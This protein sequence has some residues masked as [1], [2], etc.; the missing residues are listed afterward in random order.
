MTCIC[1]ELHE[2][3]N[4]LRPFEFPFI[5]GHIPR[6]G[7]YVLYERGEFGHDG[8][9]IVQVGTHTGVNQLRSRLQ[10]HF[11]NENKDRSI[12]RKNIGRA[13]LNRDGDPFLEY[14][15]I[16]LT[17]RKAKDRYAGVIDRDRL[18]AVEQRVSKYIQ[19]SFSFVVLPVS[20]KEE[21]LSLESKL[22]STVSWC[23]ECRPCRCFREWSKVLGSREHWSTNQRV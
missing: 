14:W 8:N 20:D 1:C 11:S 23:T 7:I 16:D 13:L 2:L 10:Q 18:L 4:H 17:S 22:I 21:R 15:E 19:D 9:R 3:L 6:N 5:A 12:L